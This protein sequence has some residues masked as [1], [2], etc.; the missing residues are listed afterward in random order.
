MAASPARLHPGHDL[1]LQERQRGERCRLQNP[2][3]PV[4]GALCVRARACVRDRLPPNSTAVRVKRSGFRLKPPS[5]I[6]FL[7][8]DW[9][10]IRT[11]NPQV[12]GQTKQV[13]ARASSR[14]AQTSSPATLMEDAA[15]REEHGERRVTMTRILLQLLPSRS[16]AFLFLS[17]NSP[18]P[19]FSPQGPGA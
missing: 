13:S 19:L 3:P 8:A 1:C 2:P 10:Q 14:E 15:P 4:I 18:P 9:K 12:A 6:F 16:P 11:Q 5:A 7:G 17:G